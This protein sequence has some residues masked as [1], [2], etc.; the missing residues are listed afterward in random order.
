MSH[1]GN[2]G[3]RVGVEP[4]QSSHFYFILENLYSVYYILNLEKILI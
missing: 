4:D 2:M 3:V 1:W